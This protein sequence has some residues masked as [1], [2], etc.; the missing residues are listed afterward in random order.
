MQT[1]AIIGVRIVDSDAETYNKEKMDT[2]LLRWGE[3]NKDKHRR[4]CNEHQKKYSL[5]VLPVYGILDKEAQVVLP[6]FESTHGYEN[7]RN[8]FS[9]LRLV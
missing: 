9:H 3:I 2:L 8:H 4:H 1:E 7:G 6:H 5:F